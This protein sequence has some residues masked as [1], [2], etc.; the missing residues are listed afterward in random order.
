MIEIRN[1][2]FRPKGD[3]VYA[4]GQRWNAFNW[5]SGGASYVVLDPE[6]RVKSSDGRVATI[7]ARD[8]FPEVPNVVFLDA[9]R[10]VLLERVM[11]KLG[12]TKRRA[13]TSVMQTPNQPAGPSMDVLRFWQRS[14]PAQPGHWGGW[15]FLTYPI[16]GEI[17]FI[18]AARTRA[19]AR[20]TV[21][22]SGATVQMEKRNGTWIARELTNFWIT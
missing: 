16:V 15:V 18:D 1:A 22:Y 7:E 11:L 10:R 17:E 12:G 6:L 3:G 20:V 2:V 14:F 4:G 21:G 13:W 19:T 5:E 9:R 8:P